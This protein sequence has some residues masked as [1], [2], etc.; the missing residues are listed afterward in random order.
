[1]AL[2][3]GQGMIEA[4]MAG[5]AKN[6]AMHRARNGGSSTGGPRGHMECRGYGPCLVA[7]VSDAA[8]AVDMLY[9]AGKCA[10]VRPI[11]VLTRTCNGME[12]DERLYL[13]ARLSFERLL[14]SSAPPARTAARVAAL[15]AAGVELNR[16]ADAQVP[17]PYPSPSCPSVLVARAT[18]ACYSRVH[19]LSPETFTTPSP[20]ALTCLGLPRLGFILSHLA[21]A[22]VTACWT[23]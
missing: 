22:G 18:G 16:R 5:S 11:D 19:R 20:L 6:A 14:A 23:P 15:R 1:M 21:I 13:S 7:G 17:A 9:D 2:R 4:R 3:A 10:A 12:I 8:R